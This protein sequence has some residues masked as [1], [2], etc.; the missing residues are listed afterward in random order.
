MTLQSS[1]SNVDKFNY[2]NSYLESTAAESVA[3]LTLT[4]ANYEEAVST[5]KRRFGNTQL[6]VDRH[7]DALLNLTSVTSHHD[8][9][10]L[11][12]LYDSVEANIRGLRALGV[13]SESYG[14]LL[15]SILMNK[16]P[17]EIRL[18]ISRD[19]TEDR[20]DMEKV[21]KIISREV[22]ARERSSTLSGSDPLPRNNS[23]RDHLL[24]LLSLLTIQPL[25]VCTAIRTTSLS[26]A[27]L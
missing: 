16:L 6:I 13:A 11:R 18:I 3:G 24:L 1:L 9:R 14:G 17:P 25:T 15:T 19:L 7:M 27:L 10:G 20:W 26:H 4:S 12:R 8:L 21:M 22:D 5:L 2:L 23:P